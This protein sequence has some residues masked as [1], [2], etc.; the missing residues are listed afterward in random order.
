LRSTVVGSADNSEKAIEI[1]RAELP[2]LVLMDIML[3]GDVNGITTGEIIKK[4]L[5]MPILF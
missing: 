5:A 1:A 2:D 4:E 3:K